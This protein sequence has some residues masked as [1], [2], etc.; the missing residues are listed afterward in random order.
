M[1]L[2]F[3]ESRGVCYDSQT[4]SF[5]EKE[6]FNTLHIQGSQVKNMSQPTDPHLSIDK[7]MT[8]A[9]RLAHL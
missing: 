3:P 9:I 8:K 6:C 5:D 4:I 7:G 1:G 2:N